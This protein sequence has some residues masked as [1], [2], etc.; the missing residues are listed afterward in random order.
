MTTDFVLQASADQSE[1]SNIRYVTQ[2]VNLQCPIYGP[3]CSVVGTGTAAEA[4]ASG[5][6]GAATSNGSVVDASVAANGGSDDASSS[7]AQ[8][9]VTAD[10]SVAADAS[11]PDESGAGANGLSG[12]S[13][14]N[15]AGTPAASR[16]RL[17]GAPQGTGRLRPRIRGG[18]DGT[19]GS[20]SRAAAVVQKG[21][22]ATAIPTIPTRAR[23]G[24]TYCG[25]VTLLRTK[26]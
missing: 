13:R 3:T 25:I 22:R 12:G 21:V 23:G 6:D 8:S 10:A 17:R 2:S 9:G 7:S 4:A 20:A 14:V 1:L 18:P 15:Q 24:S 26:T 5:P 16:R 19:R 11:V